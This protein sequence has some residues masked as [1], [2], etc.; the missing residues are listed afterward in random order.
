MTITVHGGR[1][2]PRRPA[3]PGPAGAPPAPAPG[4]GCDASGTGIIIGQCPG[5]MMI[6]APTVTHHRRARAVPVRII[7]GMPHDPFLTLTVSDSRRVSRR[8]PRTVTPRPTQCGTVRVRLGHRGRRRPG[9][10]ALNRLGSVPEFAVTQ[11]VC[12]GGS[13]GLSGCHFTNSQHGCREPAGHS[14][15]GWSLTQRRNRVRVSGRRRP[16]RD[17]RHRCSESHECLR[18]QNFLTL[19][20]SRSPPARATRLLR[21]S[22]SVCRR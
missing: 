3:G 6:I 21:A 2:P 19:G 13:R 7:R 1:P 15:V 10:P 14:A 8:L 20:L 5:I 16:G 17:R 11:P 9:P 22:G 4:P 18:D 12:A